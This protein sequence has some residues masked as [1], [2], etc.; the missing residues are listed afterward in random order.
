MCSENK[1]YY[2]NLVN[3]R[4]KFFQAVL[5]KQLN[6]KNIEQIQKEKL[7]NRK[8]FYKHMLDREKENFGMHEGQYANIIADFQ[9]HLKHI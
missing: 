1:Q 6:T 2:D 3:S 5:A 7:F 9:K 8:N 4:G